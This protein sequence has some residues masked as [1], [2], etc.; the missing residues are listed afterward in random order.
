[1]R[2]GEQ[3]TLTAGINW[4]PNSLMRFLPNWQRIDIDRIGTT[5]VPLVSNADVGQ[6]ID[7]FALRTQVAF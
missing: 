3:K 2:G 5:A 1:M 4:R 6:T 7:I